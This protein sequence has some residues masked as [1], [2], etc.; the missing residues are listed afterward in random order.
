MKRFAFFTVMVVASVTGCASYAPYGGL[1]TIAEQATRPPETGPY[2]IQVGDTVA[3]RFYR[4]PELNQDVIV[5]PD[6]YISLPFVDDVKVAGSTPAEVDA[7]LT[8]RY[9]GELAVPDVSVLIGAFGGQRIYVAGEVGSEGVH[10]LAGGTTLYMAIDQAGGFLDTAHRRQVVLIRR[11]PNGKPTGHSFDL[12]Q[13]EHG[14]NPGAD[15]LLQPYDVVYVPKNKIANVNYFVD[16][17]IRGLLPIN[18]A[19]AVRAA[20]Y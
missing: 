20:Y 5:R 17:Y 11:G 9:R 12:R 3:V 2:R 7:E 6:G 16:Q 15:V 18:P 1:P 8:K 4:N 19:S 13:V 10:D 14:T